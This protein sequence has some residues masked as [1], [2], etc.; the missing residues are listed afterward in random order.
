MR[1]PDVL[2][3]RIDVST[4]VVAGTDDP[5]AAVSLFHDARRSFAAQYDVV[6]IPGGHFCHRE[7]PRAFAQ[8]VV[9]FLATS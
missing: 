4:R 6:A 5:N 8:A 1:V 3:A 2:R 9:P 7:S